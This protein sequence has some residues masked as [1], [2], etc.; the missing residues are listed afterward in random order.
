M[1]PSILLQGSFYEDRARSLTKSMKDSPVPKVDI[2]N[3]EF[4]NGRFIIDRFTV[5]KSAAINFNTHHLANGSQTRFIMPGEYTRLRE[6]D[7]KGEFKLDEERWMV[8]MSDTPAERKDH[9]EVYAMAKELG[10]RILVHGL[11]LGVIVNA[12]LELPNIEHVTVWDI[13]EDILEHVGGF[14]LE[15][16]GS[17]RLTLVQGDAFEHKPKKGET[18]TI[19]WHDIWPTLDSD[20]LKPMQRMCA[21]FRTRVAWQE[22][23]GREVCRWM[24]KEERNEA[25]RGLYW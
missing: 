16:F 3:M 15:K 2:P 17:E 5:S 18:W 6:K 8:W 22:C 12:L 25:R 11:G 13:E 21:R 23:W 10:G 19:A 20:N 24:A 7:P 9:D 1:I 14:Y 4:G